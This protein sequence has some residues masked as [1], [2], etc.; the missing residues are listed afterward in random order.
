MSVISQL[1]D[2]FLKAEKNVMQSVAHI[3]LAPVI[4]I[5]DAG[6]MLRYALHDV[7]W[8]DLGIFIRKQR[9]SLTT[10]DEQLTTR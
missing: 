2:L 4:R 7:L 8:L 10:D 5:S 3:F 1:L 6:K 9:Y